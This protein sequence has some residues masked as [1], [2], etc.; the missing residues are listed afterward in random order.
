M[1]R[2]K[3]RLRMAGKHELRMAGNRQLHMAGKR[4]LPVWIL[5]YQLTSR[6]IQHLSCPESGLHL[7]FP[8]S[9][10]SRQ[11]LHTSQWNDLSSWI[12][13]K[14][15]TFITHHSLWEMGLELWENEIKYS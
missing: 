6:Q 12:L 3:R 15:I 10:L 8:S 2:G 1:A 4:E 5:V 9:R 14:E 11:T 7:C 13:R